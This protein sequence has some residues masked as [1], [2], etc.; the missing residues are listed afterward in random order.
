MTGTRRWL[1]NLGLVLL[2]II[3]CLVAAE[4][5][6]HWLDYEYR[7]LK[8]EVRNPEKARLQHIFQDEYF[9][10]DPLLIWRPKPDGEIFN[11]QGYR[12]PE[13][14]AHK[15]PE[16]YRI[17]AIG[18]SNT[19]GWSGSAGAHWPGYLDGL[20]RRHGDG[21]SVVNAG[22]YGYSSYQGLQ[23]FRES[24]AYDPDLVLISFGAN[25][26]H[27]VR[28][29]DGEFAR[30]PTVKWNPAGFLQ[31][32]RLGRLLLGARTRLLPGSSEAVQPRVSLDDY[33]RNLTEII[34]L[35]R[36]RGI[37]VVLLTRPYTGRID[38]EHW[39]K[40]FAHEYNL[41][42]A[43]VAAGEDVPLV[44][45]YSHFKG[46]PEYFADESHFTAAGH[47]LA[48]EIIHETL[49]SSELAQVDLEGLEID[50][51]HGRQTGEPTT[52]LSRVEQ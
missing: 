50:K 44:D 11:S 18:D 13:L 39:W 23:R 12:G 49:E 19:L 46:K 48:A 27:R 43:E 5:L 38:D 16:E 29:P 20:M 17:I 42:T 10:Y 30:D 34:R 45:V 37:E 22:V 15:S 8:I 36:E 47:L 40:N 2:S 35:A 7:P 4:L 28:T 31:R 51:S 41:A 21:F 6:L 25:D 24:I 26:A 3:F 52:R 33:R 9:V 32:Y 1:V 14:A